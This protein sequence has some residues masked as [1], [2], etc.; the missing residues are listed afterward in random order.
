MK[1]R[2]NSY[3]FFPKKIW[4][5]RKD[6]LWKSLL[7]LL[8]LTVIVNIVIFI[9][10]INFN[11]FDIDSEY[12]DYLYP[13][14]W[15]TQELPDCY[16]ENEKLLCENNEETVLED[17]DKKIV[18]IF[19]ESSE[20]SY[21]FD[22]TV[23]IFEEDGF[24]IS[25]NNVETM[26]IDYEMLPNKW[27]EINFVE[28][29]SNEDKETVFKQLIIEGINEYLISNKS[30]W[31]P[32]SIIAIIV[33]TYLGFL[34]QILPISLLGV[35]MLKRYNIKFKEYLNLFIYSLTLG[36]ILELIASLLR[37]NY[38]QIITFIIA[39]IYANI[40]INNASVK[41]THDKQ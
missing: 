18:A 41:I 14:Q 24:K 5:Y 11:G 9:E 29:Q 23:L 35:L 39:I 30:L 10:F 40:A 21:P 31:L 28:L 19:N 13:K 20:H 6:K 8:L 37:I 33:I 27:L 26:L 17:N 32:I 38:P 15:I 2:L 12:S 7:Y 16:F 34:I 22:Y 25:L 3:L 1:D 4:N 36:I